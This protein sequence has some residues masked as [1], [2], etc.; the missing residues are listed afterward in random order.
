LL[1]GNQLRTIVIPKLLCG[2]KLAIE[3]TNDVSTANGAAC[4]SLRSVPLPQKQA[5]PK[6]VCRST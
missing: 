5:L 2:V 1:R 6:R 4:V 3:V